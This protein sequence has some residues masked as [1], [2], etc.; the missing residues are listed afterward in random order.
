M[1]MQRHGD[2]AYQS[3]IDAGKVSHDLSDVVKE[4]GLEN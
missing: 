1:E 2:E 3:Y 4:L